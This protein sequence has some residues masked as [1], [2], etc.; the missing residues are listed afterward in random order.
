M[1]E[2]IDL[3]VADLVEDIEPM[4]E[5]NALRSFSSASTA[6]CPYGCASTAG[7]IG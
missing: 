5:G 6:S 2:N 4:A 1:I 3:E 7:C